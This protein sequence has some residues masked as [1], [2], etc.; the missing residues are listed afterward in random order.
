[1]QDY[2][3]FLES[4]LMTMILGGD[5]T[6]PEMLVLKRTIR[7]QINLLLGKFFNDPEIDRRY[8]DAM[9]AGVGTA[10]WKQMPTMR[11]F[12]GLCTLA[13]VVLGQ[14]TTQTFD[15]QWASLSY[16]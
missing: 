14:Q 11:D 6:T 12:L 15:G 7:A 4:A 16:S 10:L 1:M 8:L 13:N 3:A 5:S 9:N 2:I